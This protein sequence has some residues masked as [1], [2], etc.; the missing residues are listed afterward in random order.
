MNFTSF[1]G[2]MTAGVFNQKTV[3]EDLFVK[4]NHGIPQRDQ[5]R[6]TLEDFNRLSTEADPMPLPC[7]AGQPT[8][9]HVGLTCRPL[10]A[11]SVLH[12]L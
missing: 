12:R 9:R 8:N 3:K 5:Y 4:G 11:T 7:G 6:K 2:F 10:L 1:G